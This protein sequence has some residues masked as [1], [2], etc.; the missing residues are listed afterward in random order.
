MV[1]SHTKFEFST[2]TQ[3]KDMK[4]NAKYRNWVGLGLGATQGHQQY[5]HLIER[6]QLP[7][8]L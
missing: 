1:I 2:F 5:R 3:Y 7:I 8:W 4:G 6:I